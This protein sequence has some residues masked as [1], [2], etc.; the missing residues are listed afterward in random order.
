MSAASAHAA[1]SDAAA[2][3]PPRR[4]GEPAPEPEAARPDGGGAPPG[5]EPIEPASLPQLLSQL[6]HE[7]PGIVSDRVHLLSLELRRASRA[8]AELVALVVGAAVLLITAWL[9]LWG[10]LAAGAVALGLP[11]GWALV[12]VL[13]INLG[14]ALWAVQR[15]RSLAELLTLP[16]TVRRLT[17][18]PRSPAAADDGPRQRGAADAAMPDAAP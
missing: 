8:L 18:P 1:E 2:A 11:W 15:A 13:L 5:R 6:L 10:G 16:A 14:A 4:T 17:V 7:L 12:G 3:A 9:A